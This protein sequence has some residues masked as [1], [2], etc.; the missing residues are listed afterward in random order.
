MSTPLLQL[1]IDAIN[2]LRDE[3]AAYAVPAQTYFPALDVTTG[4]IQLSAEQTVLRLNRLETIETALNALV[5]ADKDTDILSVLQGVSENSTLEMGYILSI[6][7]ALTVQDFSN[8]EVAGLPYICYIL[9]QIDWRLG[10]INTSVQ[11]AHTSSNSNFD[12]VNAKLDT[13]IGLLGGLQ[14]VGNETKTIQENILIYNKLGKEGAGMPPK[15]PAATIVSQ[16]TEWRDVGN[17]R[18]YEQYW[19]CFQPR[20]LTPLGDGT[21]A[22]AQINT[23]VE[24]QCLYWGYP[25]FDESLHRFYLGYNLQYFPVIPRVFIYNDTLTASNSTY[26]S[27]LSAIWIEKDSTANTSASIAVDVRTDNTALTAS[28][29]VRASIMFLLPENYAGYLPLDVWLSI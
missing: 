2:S 18:Y 22:I 12:T 15:A 17:I 27:P 1:V 3:S 6:L 25:G 11:A 19:R 5:T 21:G 9:K 4:A 8:A 29:N 28:D 7:N 23:D 26:L 20:F 24:G 16:M 10:N 13:I 14:I